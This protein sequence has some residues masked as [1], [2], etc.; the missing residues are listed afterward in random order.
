MSSELGK[1]HVSIFPTMTGFRSKVDKEVQGVTKSASN[2]FKR[3]FAGAGRESGKS[4]GS[5]F[6]SAFAATA[7]GTVESVTNPFSRELAAATAKASAAKRTMENDAGR[8]R[9]AEL[10]LADAV[11]ESGES[12]TQAAIEQERLAAAQRKLEASTAVYNARLENQKKIQAD[13]DKLQNAA[14]VKLGIMG[15]AFQRAGTMAGT[16]FTGMKAAGL[17]AFSRLP[18]FAQTA[19][20]GIGSHVGSMMG[21]VGSM[22]SGAVSTI[23][24]GLASLGPMVAAGLGTAVMAIATIAVALTGIGVSS[25]AKYEQMV[26]G[27]DTLFKESSAK[28]Q[29]YAAQAYKTSGLS[30]NAYMEQVTGFSASLLQS[31]GGDTAKAADYADQAVRDMSDNANKFGTNIQSIQDAYQGF[32]KQNWTMLDN[33][34]LGY[35]GTKSEMER[36]IQDAN[37][38][39]EANGE[40]ADLSIDSFADITEAIH[41]IQTEMGI[42]GT[43]AHEAAST[44][45]G[46]IESA[47]AAF[48]NWVTEMGKDNGNIVESTNQLV[49]A[50]AVAA[51]N[52]LPRIVTVT[53]N[54][55]TTL[56]TNAA[57]W[58]QNDLPVL[59][60]QFSAWVDANLPTLLQKGMEMLGGI[61]SGIIQNLPQIMV[62]VAQVVATAAATILQNLPQMLQGGLEMMGNLAIGFL[63][64][65]P[66]L[67]GKIPGIVQKVWDGFCNIDWG[68]VGRNI[69]DGIKN[70]LSNAAQSLVNAAMDLGNKALDG[71]KGVLGIKSPSRVFRDQVGKMIP[72]GIS[73]GIERATPSMLATASVS[74]RRLV[75]GF[76]AAASAAPAIRA[77]GVGASARGASGIVQ[78]FTF[79]HPVE[80]PYEFA[81]AVRLRERAGLAAQ[82]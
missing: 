7:K 34:K 12:S 28:V 62:V 44:I 1:A 39:K 9:I 14:P 80:T 18:V 58:L 19:M 57:A 16:A 82:I 51:S 27:V 10:K 71:I 13:I 35:G 36:L 2:T 38:V 70:G 15:R 30:A 17:A 69:V 59:L 73:V 29:E 77:A 50:I 81:R 21:K 54:M 74:A 42:T 79:N 4:L 32:A 8:V 52:L 45:S 33:L 43:T 5:T 61:A 53:S 20:R 24:S 41:I 22:M 67:V 31:L 56:A 48:F 72:A 49:D 40:M 25:Y 64:A 78:N 23:G 55:F 37:R 63:N 66:K 65:V 76:A 6:K 46:S 11:K 26:G 47:K 68:E 60:E 75:G 3:G